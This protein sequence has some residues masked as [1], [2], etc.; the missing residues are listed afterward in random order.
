MEEEESICVDGYE[1]MVLE[2]R[3]EAA[4][5]PRFLLCDE[6][7]EKKIENSFSLQVS[8]S[9]KLTFQILHG[10]LEMLGFEVKL[11]TWQRE[12][13]FPIVVVILELDVGSNRARSAG[14]FNRVG[15]G[16]ARVLLEYWEPV[17]GCEV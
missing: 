7:R 14:S 3:D 12:N 8:H 9:I 6:R 13:H 10:W 5:N 16:F 17:D 15:V 1:N 2:L 4:L 11:E